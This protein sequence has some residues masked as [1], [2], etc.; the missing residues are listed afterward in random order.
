M[1]R[2]LPIWHVRWLF[3][4]ILSQKLDQHKHYRKNLQQYRLVI[5]FEFPNHKQLNT[6][7]ILRMLPIVSGRRLYR[8]I[9]IHSMLQHMQL[10]TSYRRYMD[11]FVSVFPI[12]IVWSMH[13]ILRKLPIWS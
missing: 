6:C 3:R 1:L 11:V 2:M 5:V 8:T 12:H 10:H 4:T 13:S 7:S 9:V